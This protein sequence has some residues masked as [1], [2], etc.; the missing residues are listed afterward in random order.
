MSNTLYPGKMNSPQTT[1]SAAYTVGDGVLSVT[2]TGVFPDA[3]N[4][5]DVFASA[6]DTTLVTY[7]YTGISGGQLTGL[8]VLEGTDKDWD[9]GTLCAR[10][11]NNYDW[12]AAID[13][14][15]DAE[16]LA[17]FMGV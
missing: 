5:V 16:I 7:R 1:L 13:H 6:L 9:A 17:I 3:P 15:Q 11:F 8:T 10:N 2:D 4:E 12:Q 14:I